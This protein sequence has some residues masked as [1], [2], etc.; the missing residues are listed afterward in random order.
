MCIIFLLTMERDIY[1]EAE[2]LQK[3]IQNDPR[4]KKLNE[5][6]KKMEEDKEV[7][8]LAYQKDVATTEYSDILN[9]YDRE[10]EIAKKY[11]HNLYLAKKALD[12]HPLVQQYLKAYKEVRELYSSINEIL[13][14][15]LSIELCPKEK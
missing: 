5:L 11:Q 15:D 14:S 9:I 12:E 3:I 2:N 6:E 10:N 7:I 13:F 1:L 4:I 8:L